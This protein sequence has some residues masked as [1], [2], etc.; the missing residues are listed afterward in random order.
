MSDVTVHENTRDRGPQLVVHGPTKEQGPLLNVLYH[1]RDYG[2]EASLRS[3]VC[4]FTGGCRPKPGLS[5]R[6]HDSTRSPL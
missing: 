2:S 3:T 4:C 6:P 1:T 5:L